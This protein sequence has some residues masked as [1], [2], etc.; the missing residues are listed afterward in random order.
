MR[1]NEPLLLVGVAHVTRG[2]ILISAHSDFSCN[3]DS[4][5]IEQTAGGGEQHTASKSSFIRARYS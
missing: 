5:E 2:S 3:A 4:D 1:D